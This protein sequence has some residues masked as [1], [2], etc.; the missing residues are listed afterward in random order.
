MASINKGDNT[1]SFGNDFL[2]IYL[3]NPNHMY[4]QKALVQINGDLEKE[5]FEPV[6][7]LR[8]NF[9]GAE[10][11][12]LQQINICK[13]A[14]WDEHGRR[15]TADGKFTFYVKE[16]RINAPDEPDG[17]EEEGYPDETAITFDLS[18]VEFAAEFTINATPQKMSELVQDIPIMLPENII[19]GRNITT[20]IEDGNVIIDADIEAETSYN[21]LTDK[22]RINGE[23]LI[24]NMTISCEQV[25]ADWRA[26]YGK[27]QI[28]NKPNLANVAI[29]GNWNDIVGKP[30]IP[31]KTSQ[32]Q[33]DSGFINDLTDYYTKEEVDEIISHDVDLRPVYQRIEELE[34]KEEDDITEVNSNLSKK[35][36]NSTFNSTVSG[37][38]QTDRELQGWIAEVEDNL[39]H[40]NEE[41]ETKASQTALDELAESVQGF[42]DEEELNTALSS[43]ATKTELNNGLNSKANKTYVHDGTLTVNVNGE[44]TQFTANSDEDVTV[45]INIPEKL[46]DL[47]NDSHFVTAEEIS[48]D[49]FATKTQLREGLNTKADKTSIGEGILTLTDGGE[50]IGSFNANSPTNKSIELNIPKKLSDI[51]Q[52]IEYVRE[53][54]LETI[55]SDIAGIKVENIA[56]GNRISA[57]ENSLDNKVQKRTGYSLMLDSEINRL[58]GVTNYND[59]AIQTNIEVLSNTVETF[60]NRINNKVDKV[61]GK[62]LSTNDY[63]ND[64]K[65]ILHSTQQ[66]LESANEDISSLQSSVGTLNTELT[67][68]SGTVTNNNTTLSGRITNETDNRMYADSVLQEQIEA[69]Q[70][71]STVVDILA[72]DSDLSHY[73][74]SKLNEGDVLCI[75]KDEEHNDTVSYYRWT[76]HD[77]RYVGSEGIYYTKSESDNKFISSA[78]EINGHPI[79]TDINLNYEDVNALPASTVIGNGT[80]T[81]YAKDKHNTDPTTNRRLLRE[82]TMNQESNAT[83]E[84]EIPTDL[85]DLTNE[86]NFINKDT[87]LDEYLGRDIPENTLIQDEIDNL[88][89]RVDALEGDLP[90]AALTGEFY[91]LKSIPNTIS[92]RFKTWKDTPGKL[93]PTVYHSNYT[94]YI[95]DTFISELKAKTGYLTEPDIDYQFARVTDIPQYISQLE[96]DRGYIT[97]NAV[98]RGNITFK[99]QDLVIG[100]FNAN[101]KDDATVIIPVDTALSTTSINP[102]QNKLVTVELNKKA[103]DTAVVHN[104][105]NESISGNKTFTGTTSLSDATGK[106]VTSTDNSTKLATTAFV[107][108]QSYAV[109]S[110]V[111]HNTTNETI[112][113]NKTFTGTTSLSDATGKTVADSDN[114]TKLAT[115]EWVKNQGYAADNKVVHDGGNETIN[116]N[117]TFAETVTFNGI[118]NLTGTI[119]HVSTPD[120][121]VND[122]VVNVAYLNN[123]IQQLQQTI[124]GLEQRIQTLEGYHS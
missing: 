59:T 83:V 52:D 68:L 78:V 112:A 21:D 4:I 7:P 40:T 80:I 71:K 75:L 13:L 58:A 61:S 33:N 49:N 32:L 105:G 42:I 65:N 11:E 85:S 8:V 99:L 101:S 6:F 115:T 87:L 81:F 36:N 102:V 38:N 37:L 31:S 108:A 45:E 86:S 98:G 95:D 29:S 109:D 18:E 122:A 25:N 107:K 17:M 66:G 120:G 44:E 116:G 119:T 46:S 26:T 14:L 70:A 124:Q 23:E 30:T 2:R 60:D 100:T 89:T 47:E 12:M 82:I 96:N 72:T 20:S 69:L 57:V 35:V 123:V 24:G 1:A 15:R 76:N 53:L 10:T 48:L 118:T 19:G 64:E 51:E 88:N 73:D 92:L 74:T 50:S 93:N 34:T 56:Q 113:G 62:G 84:I 28:L 67:S 111:V 110:K 103:V 121:T 94:D 114:S 22:P 39:T 3:N 104:T 91:D 54:D 79:T 77:F 63:S 41:V 55:Q 43:Y 5:Y 9:T 106:T 16:N 117:K 97:M 90:D 27:A